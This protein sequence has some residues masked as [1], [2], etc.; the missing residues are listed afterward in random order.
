MQTYIWPKLTVS[1]PKLLFTK[2]IRN[3]NEI[4][5]LS[6]QVDLQI[7][8]ITIQHY[9]IQKN[10]MVR[11]AIF[12]PH[13]HLVIVISFL[14]C[15]LN[16]KPNYNSERTKHEYTRPTT[17]HTSM[18]ERAILDTER[19]NLIA[20][21]YESFSSSFYLDEIVYFNQRKEIKRA[22]ACQLKQIWSDTFV[23]AALACRWW[24]VWEMSNCARLLFYGCLDLFHSPVS[25]CSSPLITGLAASTLQ[26]E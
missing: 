15:N 21:I 23:F 6:I 7:D 12:F 5:K 9:T 20:V 16:Y 13:K 18:F 11:L 4:Q 26:L 22:W 10:Q 14:Q 24:R 2:A 3:K 25:P 1:D 19:F 17:N 8:I